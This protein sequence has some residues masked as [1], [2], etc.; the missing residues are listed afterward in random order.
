LIQQASEKIER[1]TP[2]DVV[3]GFAG[4]R[5]AGLPVG[6]APPPASRGDLPG[7]GGPDGT[8]G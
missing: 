6:E 8:W 2:R 7:M 3:G 1:L 4:W 5:E